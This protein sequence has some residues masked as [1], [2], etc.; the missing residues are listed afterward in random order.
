MRSMRRCWSS[1]GLFRGDT[2]RFSLSVQITD[3]VVWMRHRI[4]P[5]DNSISIWTPAFAG[6]HGGGWL[7]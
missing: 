1:F 2:A 4:Q 6:V 7:V 5:A 3:P